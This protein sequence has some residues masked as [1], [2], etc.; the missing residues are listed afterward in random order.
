VIRQNPFPKLQPAVG[1][2]FNFT[3]S[4]NSA[5]PTMNLTE[6]R[7]YILKRMEDELS[8]DYHYHSIEHTLDVHR[9]CIQL[10]QMESVN[11]S[12]LILL[13]TAAY[14]HDC[15]ILETYRDHEEAS[16][17]IAREVLPEY[18]YS[19][20]DLNIIDCVIM[21]TK[22]PQS[23]ITLLG[24]ILCDADLDYLGRPD[25]FMIAHRLR[26]EW[27]LMGIFYDLQKWYELQF[28]FLN[29]H[30]YYTRAARLLRN[31]GKEKNLA[32]VR[33]ILRK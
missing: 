15:G 1:L 21:K 24:E 14:F 32:E 7:D 29:N 26:Y 18:G 11:G 4:Y 6:A 23:A 30:R 12:D 31:E 22:L 27:E 2:I 28:N 13:E 3:A 8:P 9:A 25:F 33:K 17:K 5:I 10:A 16:V 19:Q 20:A